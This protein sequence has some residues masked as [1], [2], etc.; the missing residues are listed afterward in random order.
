[1]KNQRRK[2]DKLSQDKFGS[3]LGEVNIDPPRRYREEQRTKETDLNKTEIRRR[4]S[5]K[6]RLKN[7]VRKALIA[8][9]L[10]IVL[11]AVG[12][13]LS[14]TV[15]FKIDTIN[16]TGSGVYSSEEVL[17]NCDISYG[18]NLFMIKKDVCKERLTRNLPYIYDVKI[19]RKLPATVQLEII[20][21]KVQYVIDNENET[22]ILLDD[23][24]KVL[25]NASAVGAESAV[26]I[27]NS[28]VAS[29]EKGVPISFEDEAVSEC[30]SKLSQAIKATQMTQATSISSTD[31][32]NN[33]IIYDGRIKFTLGS[34]DDIENKI[35]KG[36]AACEKLDESSP[37]VKGI[38]TIGTDKQIYFTAD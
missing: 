38:I 18:D 34:C 11:I 25:D 16:I 35:Y 27:T 28:V 10:L 3:S 6:R 13:V 32:N 36:L 14:L 2:T 23:N 4:Q 30:L 24:F 20:D 8:I 19:T 12:I 5:K 29:A 26:L 9:S 31:V 37:G 7:S 1:M 15:F 21:A 17:S 33:Y 22:F